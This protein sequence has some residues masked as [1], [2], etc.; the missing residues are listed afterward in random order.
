M[1]V[2]GLSEDAQE[3]LTKAQ[4]IYVQ[5]ALLPGFN[6]AKITKSE[7]KNILQ[8]EPT[9]WTVHY[10]WNLNVVGLIP[11]R[12]QQPDYVINQRNEDLKPE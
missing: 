5:T 4:T 1:R 12:P 8:E 7:A 3:A 2:E 11:R 6:W 9:R 10:V